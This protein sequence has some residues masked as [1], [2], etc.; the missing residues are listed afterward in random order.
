MN[1]EDLPEWVGP[2]IFGGYGY[3]GPETDGVWS[4]VLRPGDVG[5]RMARRGHP[6][7]CQ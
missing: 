4:G 3:H 6:R 2:R 7:E 5:G 1:G